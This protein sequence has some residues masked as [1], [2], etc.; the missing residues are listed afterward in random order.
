MSNNTILTGTAL[1][2]LGVVVTIASSSDSV[3]SMIPA[4]IG[5]VFVVIGVGAK[6]KPDLNH[7]FMHAAAALALLSIV[8]SLGSALG[9]GATGWALFAQIATIVITGAFLFLAVNSFR[10]ARRARLADRPA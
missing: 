2:F 7:H 3:T 9:R 10:A 4:F 8:A 1:I 5:V 6:F